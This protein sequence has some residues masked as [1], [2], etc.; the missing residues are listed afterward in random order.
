MV[1]TVQACE[2]VCPLV[3]EFLESDLKVS[4]LADNAAAISAFHPSMGSWRN[5]HLRMRAL[6]GREKIESGFLTVNYVPGEL[7]VADIGT[8]ALSSSKL[9]GLLE[10]VNVRIPSKETG[11]VIAAKFFG[12]LC[13]VSVEAAKNLSPAMAF[14][15]VVLSRPAGVEAVGGSWPKVLAASVV[16]T[17]AQPREV[18]MLLWGFVDEL[19]WWLLILFAGVVLWFVWVLSNPSSTSA[20]GSSPRILGTSQGSWDLD[21]GGSQQEAISETPVSPTAAPGGVRY[22]A[23]EGCLVVVYGDDEMRVPLDGCS[24][25][26]VYSV[27]RSIQEGNWD[28]FRQALALG[29]SS[30]IAVEYH[31]LA[32]NFPM[33]TVPPNGI[34]IGPVGELEA[35]T[36]SQE[37]GDESLGG[38]DSPADLPDLEDLQDSEDQLWSP[39]IGSVVIDAV[40][41]LC[42]VVSSLVIL[43]G[44]WRTSRILWCLLARVGHDALIRGFGRTEAIPCLSCEAELVNW[45][46]ESFSGGTLVFGL[47]CLCILHRLGVV[48]LGSVRNPPVVVVALPDLGVTA[49]IPC[50]WEPRWMVWV[51]LVVVFGL[52]G[53]AEAQHLGFGVLMEGRVEED[54][55][56]GS[57]AVVDCVPSAELSCGERR[58]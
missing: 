32:S 28:Y 38:S 27:V 35:E 21:T 8:K 24:F 36:S 11:E 4:L 18:T 53:S 19:L 37:A 48:M 1:Y 55:F 23:E 39:T 15:L 6:A 56:A 3:E 50:I 46:E 13:T 42:W 33:R 14:A 10:L 34:F 58:A 22:R 40:G 44:L 2:S 26:E 30:E 16:G 17:Q 43:I 45:E 25:E 31:Q 51:F 29:G 20:S 5:R 9:L 52:C 54:L 7:Q 47:W 41:V 57:M 49:V 12:R